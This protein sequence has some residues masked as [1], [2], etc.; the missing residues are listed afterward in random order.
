MLTILCDCAASTTLKSLC[1][2]QSTNRC[3][4]H[5]ISIFLVRQSPNPRQ[6]SEGHLENGSWD[7]TKIPHQLVS[8]T[9]KHG[10]IVAF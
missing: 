7:Y 2:I 4:I 1:G 6:A 10:S 3:L 9:R 8:C 5:P